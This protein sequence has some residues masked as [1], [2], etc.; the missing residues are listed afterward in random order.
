MVSFSF[1]D[2]S[3][4]N[5]EVEHHKCIVVMHPY[6]P[7]FSSIESLF[8]ED[9]LCARPQKAAETFTQSRYSAHH[10]THLSQGV[11]LASS[12]EES[13]FKMQHLPARNKSLGR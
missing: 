1:F 10:L 3:L 6:L 9:S 7:F 12:L 4:S 8:A 2:L 11:C 13:A 5:Q